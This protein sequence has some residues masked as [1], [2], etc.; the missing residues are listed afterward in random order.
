MDEPAPNYNREFL[1]S[2]H[3]VVFGLLTL[4]LGFL[5]AELFPLIVGATVYA[6]GW[7]YLPDMPFFRRSVDRRRDEAR[8][9]LEVLK[10][11][12][13]LERR[14][15]LIGSL[16]TSR[17][18]RYAQLAEVCG[19]IETAGAD[20]PLASEDPGTDPRL[21]K[22]DELMWTFLRL[23]GIEESLERFLE[24]ERRDNIPGVLK[25]AEAEAKRLSEELDELK[26]KGVS[27]SLETKQRYLGSRLERLEVL[28]KREQRITQAQENLALVVSEQERLDQ[29][30]KLIRADAVATKNAEALTARIDATVEHL[31]QTNKWLSE[32]DEFKDLVA[33]LPATE[34]RVGYNAETPPPIPQ[35]RSRVRPIIQQK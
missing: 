33:D 4:G 7:I 18:Q 14:E 24:T 3:H 28:R 1:H 13:F 32:L 9:A 5:S 26:K 23:L 20:T 22:L 31:D 29:Q 21:R 16:S 12:E 35:N 30:I 34:L 11:E 8:R 2:P 15:A 10:V 17:R 19:D 25:D 6:L 27:A